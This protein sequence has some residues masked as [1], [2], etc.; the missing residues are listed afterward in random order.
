MIHKALTAQQSREAEARAVE[1]G[2]SLASL[3]DAAGAALASE[4]TSRV[5]DGSVCVVCGPGN[6]GGD[7]W[8]A[9]RLLHEQGRAVQ[10]FSVREPDELSGIAG[11]AAKAA[12]DGGV[13]FRVGGPTDVGARDEYTVVVDALLGTGSA[14][15]LRGIV[16]DWCRWIGHAEAFVIAAD[17]PTGV[18]SDTGAVDPDGV[19]AD[20]TVAFATAKVGLVTFPGAALA[21]EVGVADIGIPADAWADAVVPEV[22]TR[23]E[24]A[25]RIPL[26]PVDA[27]KNS[28]G[29]VLVV[30]GS[31]SYPGAAVLAAL[32]AQR[33]G[34]GYV[35]LAVP[36]PVVSTAQAHLLSVPVV[37]LS[38]ED[39]GLSRASAGEVVSLSRGYDVV[40]VGPGLGGSESTVAAVREIVARLEVPVVLDADG[41]NAFAGC[42]ELLDTAGS[43]LILTPHPGELT[44]LLGVRTAQVQEDRIGSAQ[45]LA[46]ASRTIV[47]KGAGTVICSD[48]RCV[49]NVSGTPALAT[50]GTGDVLAGMVG[51]LVA[52]GCA[53]FD[54][55]ALGVYLHGLAGEIAASESSVLTVVA[56]DVVRAISGAVEQTLDAL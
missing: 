27:H 40:V 19:Y 33:C 51:S 6:N 13:E 44:R 39:G 35:T 42:A 23:Y 18:D 32:G 3:M 14:L 2:I 12:A 46:T 24:Y 28:R 16:A 30:G 11:D 25:A 56:E 22:W 38:A 53:P 52:A 36:H 20:A 15:P 17:L 29:R 55:A 1:R 5:P 31:A 54:A 48:A 26:P 4:V 49:I 7:G 41:L 9:A 50:A 43:P 10:V 37:G 34:A 8:V 47:L 21:G 45:R